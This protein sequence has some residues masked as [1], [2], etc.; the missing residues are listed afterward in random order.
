MGLTNLEI[1]FRFLSYNP[2][3]SSDSTPY[4]DDYYDTATE[5]WCLYY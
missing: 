2:Y 5:V 1:G 3:D 4:G